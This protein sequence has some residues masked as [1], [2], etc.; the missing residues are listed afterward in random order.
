MKKLTMFVAAAAIAVSANAQ[1]TTVTGHKTFDNIYVGANFGASSPITGNNMYNMEHDKAFKEF[2]GK[3]G[4]RVGKH[5]TSVFGLAIEGEAYKSFKKDYAFLGSKT[6]VNSVDV[7]LLSTWNLNNIFAGY[8]GEP[9]AFE[10]FA[11]AGAGYGHVF[12]ANGFSDIHAKVGLDFAYNFGK[13]KEWQVYL[14]P[15]LRYFLSETSRTKTTVD[16]RFDF[17]INNATLQLSVG[18]N[19]KFKNSNGTH[20]F[21]IEQVRD[22]AEFDALNAQ[23]NATR[24][25]NNAVK[26]ENESLKAENARLRKALSDCE[27]KPAVTETSNAN[28][29]PSVIFAQGKSLVQKSQMPNIEMIA[30]Y[31][32]NNPDARIKISGYASPEGSKAFNQKLSEK[33]ADAVKSILVKKYNIDADRLETE[34]LGATDKLFDEVEFN[35]VAIFNTTTK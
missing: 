22:Q 7:N 16:N 5:I 31:M 2:N 24:S 27:N 10:V 30:K 18:V 15:S 11:I 19:Y 21:A 1:K 33:R 25:E 8:K 20:N 3:L 4:I 34:G 6:F 32:K 29:Q 17:N 12:G 35:R 13:N 26:A 23:I 28:L 14:E 9:R